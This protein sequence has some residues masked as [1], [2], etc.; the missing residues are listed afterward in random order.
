MSSLRRIE[1]PRNGKKKLGRKT[2]YFKGDSFNDSP[3]E[4]YRVVMKESD[5]LATVK[6]NP[7]LSYGGDTVF[8]CYVY[9]S[10]GLLL[11]VEYPKKKRVK[12]M[13]WN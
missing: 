6:K 1:L 13:K 8:P 9:D 7:V 2:D 10:T 12:P 4:E 11:R 5:G 3:L